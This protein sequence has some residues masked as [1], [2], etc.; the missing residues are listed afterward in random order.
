MSKLHRYYYVTRGGLRVDV[1]CN[2]DEC[3]YVPGCKYIYNASE[4]V[5]PDSGL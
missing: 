3:I 4:Y 5:A 2:E 1:T